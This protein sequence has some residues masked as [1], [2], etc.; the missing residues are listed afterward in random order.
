MYHVVIEE[1]LNKRIKK[2]DQ[3][4]KDLL[5]SYILNRLEEC[6]NP[7]AFGKA[8]AAN[9]S[10]IWRYRVGDYRLLVEIND[11]QLIIFAIEF[12]HRSK[13]CN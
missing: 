9:L 3:Q 10:G 8:L 4:V 2:L 13:V 6:Q 7:R 5:K 11:D 1:K 12:A